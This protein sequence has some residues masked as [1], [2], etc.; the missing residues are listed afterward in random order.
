LLGPLIVLLD[1]QGPAGLCGQ[2]AAT[3]LP[4]RPDAESVRWLASVSL[5]LSE[6]KE[7]LTETPSARLPFPGP[8][9]AVGPEHLVALE[10]YRHDLVKLQRAVARWAKK[11]P[12]L[13]PAAWLRLLPG[14]PPRRT[15]DDLGASVLELHNWHFHFA[16]SA[17]NMALG[18]SGVDESAAGNELITSLLR[19]LT[20]APHIGIEPLF[21]STFEAEASVDTLLPVDS[22]V[23][24]DWSPLIV[25]R[26]C[27]VAGCDFDEPSA[28]GLGVIDSAGVS[29][30][31]APNRLVA[32]H[33]WQSAGHRNTSRRL[34]SFKRPRSD[35]RVDA[36]AFLHRLLLEG[37]EHWTPDQGR[38]HADF[39]LE[40]F[41]S[42]SKPGGEGPETATSIVNLAREALRGCSWYEFLQPP[43]EQ[44]QF[45]DQN[46]VK[47]LWQEGLAINVDGVQEVLRPAAH[48]RY[49]KPPSKLF[50]VLDR[51]DTFL[52]ATVG[53]GSE[54][55]LSFQEL[56]QMLN[57]A[58][59]WDTLRIAELVDDLPVQL[60]GVINTVDRGLLRLMLENEAA[61]KASLKQW[62]SSLA[63]VISLLN[64]SIRARD[65]NADEINV[66]TWGEKAEKIKYLWDPA[67]YG[68]RV[69]F[70]RRIQVG[71]RVIQETE[72]AYSAG[73]SEQPA[74][75]EI[76]AP[77]YVVELEKNDCG[78]P[79][80][81]STHR[82]NLARKLLAWLETSG[83]K[84]PVDDADVQQFLEM[85]RGKLLPRPGS[86]PQDVPYEVTG[87]QYSSSIDPGNC[88]AV[89]CYTIRIED[90]KREEFL[91]S[92]GPAPEPVKAK[93]W[94]SKGP[95][96]QLLA[97]LRNLVP[98]DPWVS[99]ALKIVDADDP[100]P[101]DFE[102]QLVS[103]GVR[104]LN[105][106]HESFLEA[107]NDTTFAQVSDLVAS[108]RAIDA[109][110]FPQPRKDGEYNWKKIDA[111]LCAFNA[112]RPAD[113]RSQWCTEVTR[114]YDRQP[115]AEIASIEK[116][117]ALY[118]PA[119]AVELVGEGAPARA[120]Y[121]LSLGPRSEQWQ[122]ANHC[123]A[124]LNELVT[125]WPTPFIGPA[126]LADHG[127]RL[128]ELQNL[129]GT[130]PGGTKDP[131]ASNRLLCEMLAQLDSISDVIFT[132]SDSGMV[133]AAESEL[134]GFDRQR[135][136]LV[137]FLANQKGVTVTPDW[138]AQPAV[139]PAGRDDLIYHIPAPFGTATGDQSVRQVLARRYDIGDQRIGPR[140]IV[141]V[142]AAKPLPDEADWKLIHGLYLALRS[143]HRG[144]PSDFVEYLSASDKF[145]EDPAQ[146]NLLPIVQAAEN[147]CAV[148]NDQA[149]PPEIRHA[150]EALEA[151]L[152][153][154]SR[155]TYWPR[156]GYPVGSEKA[157]TVEYT[158]IPG[159]Q[160][161]EV[162][163]ILAPAYKDA[164]GLVRIRGRI[165]L[166][167]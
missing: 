109:F 112:N 38:A 85:V 41:A 15:G 83:R 147:L 57:Q 158:H 11:G 151:R 164:S 45:S 160:P 69:V 58:E 67:P 142:W 87:Y 48:F 50:E 21:A 47:A 121:I 140:F 135:A 84:S 35:E 126:E 71:R 145:L 43:P 165:R 114:R 49:V 138:P 26:L 37:R 51:C 1:P 90:Q 33:V 75:L 18:L 2:L 143:A 74:L 129:S 152:S 117:I 3:W 163:R 167:K 128:D 17:L 76:V 118:S 157:Y 89:K 98:Q 95:P 10:Q 94:L 93:V 82:K 110:I 64:S 101:T 161:K 136:E 159:R 34:L 23:A 97:M 103:A 62:E 133:G 141:G 106:A 31:H 113:W 44:W 86:L 27:G 132:S 46:D 116:F 120:R 19:R 104:A 155:V 29:P 91:V 77:E 149:D 108:M 99:N 139:P 80:C 72:L 127:K 131:N 107:P 40:L 100:L 55:Y 7:Q 73:A 24:K 30:E 25:P 162:V 4:A 20:P 13:L 122:V 102:S 36:A 123:V 6:F 153:D 125:R 53:A 96:P 12:G 111:E 166:T 88:V 5:K 156:E 52:A 81:E 150:I 105:R 39:V 28:G 134:A 56:K 148:R 14:E 8:G 16:R 65:A 54:S 79:L 146:A 92:D 78:I 63:A 68:R 32:R 119:G 154:L 22:E 61:F 137:A 124:F 70:K 9:L 60:R 144:N 130:G 42:T 115:K 66:G 59:M